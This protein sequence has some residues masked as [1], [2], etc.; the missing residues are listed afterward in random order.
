MQIIKNIPQQSD[1]WFA[2]RK[3]VM[4]ASHAQAIGSC[5]KG[6]DSYILELM[7]DFYAITS[8]F[9][10]N[11]DM[12]RGNELEASARLVYEMEKGVTVEEVTFVKM[13]DCIGCSPDGLIGDD[14]LLE[15][16]CPNNKNY[17]LIMLDP[18]N[19]DTKYLW[20][21]Q[22]Q[23]LV[24]GRKWCDYMAYNPNFEKHFTIYRFG[25]DAEKQSKLLQGFEVGKRAIMELKNQVERTKQNVISNKI[26]TGVT[27]TESNKLQF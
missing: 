1:E 6:L 26:P 22:M 19:I 24:T 17:F 12:E 4:T 8:D 11:P 3:G 14:G 9:Y 16:K 21:M 5:G 7:A 2:M 23:M 27:G 25:V 13:D 20:Q 15:I 10:T 18:K